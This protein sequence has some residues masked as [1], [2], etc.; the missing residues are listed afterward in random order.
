MASDFSVECVE[1]SN[2]SA[3]E[4]GHATIKLIGL[5]AFLV[6]V[7]LIFAAVYSSLHPIRHILESRTERKC[8]PLVDFAVSRW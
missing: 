2:F 8:S 4:G 6:I 7:P 3:S 1:A 5:V